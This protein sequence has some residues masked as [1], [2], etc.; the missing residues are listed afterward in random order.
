VWLAVSVRV[1]SLLDEEA[2]ETGIV[3]RA[4]SEDDV[5]DEGVSSESSI[6]GCRRD[7]EANMSSPTSFDAACT[8]VTSFSR[9]ADPTG[10]GD[11][12]SAYHK[13]YILIKRKNCFNRNN[14]IVPPI[15][16]ILTHIRFAVNDASKS[17]QCT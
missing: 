3:V 5:L 4:G 16:R 14:T 13:R 7:A 17:T 15:A 6:T 1:A 8:E 11:R 10:R 2:G 9:L 12:M